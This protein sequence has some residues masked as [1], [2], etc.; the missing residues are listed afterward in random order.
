MKWESTVS[1]KKCFIGIQLI[2]NIVLVS[3]VQ[4]SESVIHTHIQSFLLNRV[5]TFGDSISDY[6]VTRF[7][8]FFFL[9][10]IVLAW[11]WC[12]RPLGHLDSLQN[13][14]K[15]WLHW[16]SYP[17]TKESLQGH[18][19]LYTKICWPWTIWVGRNS[20]SFMNPDYANWRNSIVSYGRY[21]VDNIIYCSFCLWQYLEWFRFL[22]RTVGK[23]MV[24]GITT[25][26]QA[27]RIR[28]LNKKI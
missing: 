24:V 13:C 18:T 25:S 16:Y 5:L 1:F 6:F 8:F 23:I 27:G 19:Y 28:W 12:L 26:F 9:H 22:C 20:S 11:V 10:K 2:Y 17:D 7:F 4:Q 3:G 21:E 15:K 14:I